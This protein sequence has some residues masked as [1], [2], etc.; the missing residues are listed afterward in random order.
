MSELK[1]Y[2]FNVMVYCPRCGELMIPDIA[3]N[4]FTLCCGNAFCEQYKILY[5]A[6]SMV[7]EPIKLE[8]N[9]I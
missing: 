2:L 4:A 5:K 6:P 7:L 3:H 8:T 9:K 1:A